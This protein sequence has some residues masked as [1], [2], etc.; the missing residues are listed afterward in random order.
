MEKELNVVK[1]RE[2][3]R[4]AERKLEEDKRELVRLR[5]GE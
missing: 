5:R 4:A 2:R 1:N 3:I